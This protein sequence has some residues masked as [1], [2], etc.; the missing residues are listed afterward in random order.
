MQLPT[1]PPP[2]AA[3]TV[4][5]VL[6]YLHPALSL[7]LPA[8]LVSHALAQRHHFLGI[9]PSDAHAYL[10]WPASSPADA[11]A[12][13]VLDALGALPPH[14]DDGPALPVRYTADADSAYAHVLAAVPALDCTL[15]LVFQW[16]GAEAAWKYHDASTAPLPPTSFG[17]PGDALAA[18]ARASS[19]QD[20]RTPS[21]EG[22]DD[23][24]NSYGGADD[25]D[26]EH[27]GTSLQGTAT[28]GGEDAYWAQY[29]SVHGASISNIIFDIRS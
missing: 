29:N 1:A 9:A 8:H 6:A 20:R 17:L 27:A 24:W 18:V 10:S 13:S 28:P 3:H 22:D 23:Y 21:S 4:A 7:P 11:A 2:L 25:D 19:S 12:P 15:R 16:D 14:A 26:R 5:T